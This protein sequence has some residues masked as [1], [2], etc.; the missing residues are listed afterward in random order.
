MVVKTGESTSSAVHRCCKADELVPSSGVQQGP[1]LA[2]GLWPVTITHLVLF[3][4][5]NFPDLVCPHR[6]GCFCSNFPHSNRTCT[7]SWMLEW[8]QVWSSKNK[9]AIRQMCRGDLVPIR[10]VNSIN[11]PADSRYSRS[12][13]YLGPAQKRWLLGLLD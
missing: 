10:V 2:Q 3:H 13:H 11:I 6:P 4:L 9:T 5:L 12:P 8:W 7:P 1:E